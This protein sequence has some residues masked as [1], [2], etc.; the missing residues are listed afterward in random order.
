MKKEPEVCVL[1]CEE[2][3][4]L[5]SWKDISPDGKWGHVCR[6]KNFRKEHR[7]ESYVDTYVRR[8][9]Q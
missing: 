4:S 7:C 5:L 9:K 2:C 8:R 3:T 1:I 6:A